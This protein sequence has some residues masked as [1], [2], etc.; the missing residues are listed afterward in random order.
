MHVKIVYGMGNPHPFFRLLLP[1]ERNQ[2]LPSE[3]RRSGGHMVSVTIIMAVES[4]G[5]RQLA[6]SGLSSDHQ[7]RRIV[8]CGSLRR[9]LRRALQRSGKLD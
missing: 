1:L 5:R 2:H 8:R 3:R 7:V 6:R 9:E 4:L